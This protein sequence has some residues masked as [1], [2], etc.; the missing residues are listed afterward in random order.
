MRAVERVLPILTPDATVRIAFMPDKEDPDSLIRSGGRDAFQGVLDRALSL[1]DFI[2]EL[3][4]QGEDAKTADGR[5]RIEGGINQMMEKVTDKSVQYS[6]RSV[7]RDKL[8]AAIRAGGGGFGGGAGGGGGGRPRRLLPG[9]V[10]VS[11]LWDSRYR[12]ATLRTDPRRRER[13]LLLPILHH[14]D[15]FEQVGELLAGA[16]FADGDLEAMRQALVAC[17]TA[18]SALDV[19]G[20]KR[21][22]STRGFHETLDSLLSADAPKF[23]QPG[24]SIETALSGWQEVWLSS[25]D[26]L[27]Q[28]ELRDAERRFA[29]TFSEDDLARL[30][31]LQRELLILRGHADNL[32]EL[33]E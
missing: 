9:E 14:P 29:E 30:R 28:R 15:L 23:A 10:P 33:G 1:E 32:A 12:S 2:W 13:Y 8:R 3:V 6:Y 5:L 26:G 25:E 7:L 4:R 21:H 22:L 11:R 20:L 31:A 27:L 16:E 19:D 24:A 17:L 18:E